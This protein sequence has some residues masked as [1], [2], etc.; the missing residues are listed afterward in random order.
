MTVREQIFAEIETRLA[1]IPTVQSVEREPNGDP[2]VFDYLAITDG[3]QV[4]IEEECGVTRYRL[5]VDIEGYVEGSG[6]P[7]THA[8]LSALY[9]DCV[10]ALL[11]DP[12]LGG[13]AETISEDGLRVAVAD[14]AN[15]RRMGFGLGISIEFSNQR[16]NPALPA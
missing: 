6:G 1:A 8:A 9:A 16:D 15:V 2:D 7:A 11:T 13:L 10:A 5:S 12:P 3:G 14:L 4:V